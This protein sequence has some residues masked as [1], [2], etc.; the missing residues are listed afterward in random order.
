LWIMGIRGVDTGFPGIA[1]D[2]VD[3]CRSSLWI[4]PG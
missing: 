1:V 4:K 2:D 3:K